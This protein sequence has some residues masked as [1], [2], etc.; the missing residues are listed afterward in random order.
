MRHCL[1]GFGK[2]GQAGKPARDSQQPERSLLTQTFPLV[3]GK[4]L[5]TEDNE[6]SVDDEVSQVTS[7][8]RILSEAWQVA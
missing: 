3:T 2:T 7:D 8:S 6:G 5:E 1:Y 4:S